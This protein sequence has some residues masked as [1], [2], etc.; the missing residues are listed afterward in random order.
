MGAED[1]QPATPDD[2]APRD[3]DIPE[4]LDE[5]RLEQAVRAT[6][7]RELY[8][9][10]LVVRKHEFDVDEPPEIGGGD[11]GPSPLELV[12]SALASCTAIT[13]RM[14]ADRKEWPL[15]EIEARVSHARFRTERD[16]NPSDVDRFTLTLGLTGPIDEAQ[17]ERLM[18]IAGRCPVHRLLVAGSV[19][20]VRSKLSGDITEG[21]AP[22]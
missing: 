4:P 14:Y 10:R 8:R 21:V 9:T 2:G 22:L 12:C 7:G 19:V 16:G 20:E 3:A 15:E 11:T 1:S 18:Q 17:R 6:T 13:L 5:T